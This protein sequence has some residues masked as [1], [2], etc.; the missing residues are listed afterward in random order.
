M[1]RYLT[2]VLRAYMQQKRTQESMLEGRL[3]LLSPLRRLLNESQRLDEARRRLIGA[4]FQSVSFARTHLTGAEK[5]LRALDPLAVLQRGYA[6]IQRKDGIT[7][8][9]KGLVHPGDDIHIRVSD[10]SFEAQVTSE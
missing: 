5:R 10:G 2:D 6:V 4:Q 3:R 1:G 9:R 7:V 8:G